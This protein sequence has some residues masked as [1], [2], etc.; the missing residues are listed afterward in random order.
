MKDSSPRR[1][2]KLHFKVREDFMNLV[3]LYYGFQP[4]EAGPI[5]MLVAWLL[6]MLAVTTNFATGYF[7][8]IIYMGKVYI[9]FI[10]SVAYFPHSLIFLS[11]EYHSSGGVDDL[12]AWLMTSV[13][14]T[15]LFF[16]NWNINHI[17]CLCSSDRITNVKPLQDMLLAEPELTRLGR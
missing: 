12:S 17:F 3:L 5:Q 6:L 9:F 4:Q 16:L 8:W 15:K 11:C 14:S 13:R 10:E 2:Q 1:R 7:R